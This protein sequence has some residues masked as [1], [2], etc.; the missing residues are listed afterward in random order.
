M[1]MATS[2]YRLSKCLLCKVVL[3]FILLYSL[4]IRAESYKISKFSKIVLKIEDS[5]NLAEKVFVHFDKPYYTSG[6]YIWFK[7]YLVNAKSN[8]PNAF[9]KIV[10]V[11]LIDQSNKI[12]LSRAVKID[13][14]GGAGEFPLPLHL[15]TGWYS[16]RAYSNMMRNFG[17]DFFFNKRIKILALNEVSVTSEIVKNEIPIEKVDST[18]V[19]TLKPDIQFFPEG[20][21]LVNELQSGPQ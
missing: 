19:S 12:I 21:Q 11:D 17:H 14:G 13:A 3:L 5:I 4:N 8:Q 7:V 6:E 18:D 10:H 2:N 9:S 16:I 20:G 1:N 15:K